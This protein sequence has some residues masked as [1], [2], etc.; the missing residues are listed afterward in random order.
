MGPP[1]TSHPRPQATIT[2]EQLR[3]L[4]WHEAYAVKLIDHPLVLAES[5]GRIFDI[6]FT[7][8]TTDN[9]ADVIDAEDPNCLM[10][11]GRSRA[12]GDGNMVY[13]FHG[14]LIDEITPLPQEEA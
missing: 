6:D 2:L 1:Q 9:Q 12:P 7:H 3:E 10:V 4:N 14:W 11:V 13:A 8:I 5:R